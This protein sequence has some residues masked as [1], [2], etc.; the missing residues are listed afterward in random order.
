[1][2]MMGEGGYSVMSCIL[3]VRKGTEDYMRRFNVRSVPHPTRGQTF[4][5]KQL[6]PAC[7]N[8]ISN[9]FLQ[10]HLFIII[11]LEY[12]LYFHKTSFQ[13]KVSLIYF[14]FL[15]AISDF[16]LIIGLYVLCV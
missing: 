13:N 2:G 3:V 14:R 15:F 9:T 10:L 11:Q 8:I 16:Q 5:C 7:K 1:M 6:R 4:L 12:I